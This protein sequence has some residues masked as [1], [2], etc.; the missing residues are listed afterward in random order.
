MREK[1]YQYVDSTTITPRTS[2]TAPSVAIIILNYNTTQAVIQLYQQISSLRKA[3]TTIIPS[4]LIIDNASRSKEA[5]DLK[6]FFS[7]RSDVRL[8]FSD[9]NGGYSQG[10][11]LGLKK[12][13]ELDIEYCLIANGDIAFLTAD[14]LEQLVQ[15]ACSLPNCGLIGPKVVFQNGKPQGPLRQMGVI[16]SFIASRTKE[17]IATEPVYAT[18]GCCIFGATKTFEAIKFFDEATFLYCEEIILAER[19]RKSGLSWYYVPA[20]SVQHNHVRKIDSLERMLLHKKYLAQ[21]AIYYFRRYKNR[22]EAAVLAY[23]LLL[24][25]KVAIYILVVLGSQIIARLWGRSAEN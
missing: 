5:S 20:V 6:A 24:S 7:S 9:F 25:A 15:A 12:A 8:I 4:Y 3:F 19:L 17:I 16:S 21:S 13:A 14:F 22:S 2:S 23:R 11:N 10:N 18:V 1:Y